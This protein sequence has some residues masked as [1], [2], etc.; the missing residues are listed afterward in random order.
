MKIIGVTGKSGSGKT[1]FAKKLA[2]SLNGV[3]VD[4]DRVSKEPLNK[5]NIIH[6][7]CE[8]FG[9]EILDEKGNIDTKKL[10]II[11]FSK[12][13]WLNELMRITQKDAEQEI[14][15]ILS[16]KDN[17]IVVL[18]WIKLPISKYWEKCDTKIL[19]KADHIKRKS[20]VLERD[21]ISEEYFEKRDLSAI[22]YEESDFNYIF[23]NNYNEKEMEETIDVISLK[24]ME[25]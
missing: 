23:K 8:K 20:K 19:V 24:I 2:K 15:D 9:N 16:K 7:L 4:V 12:E 25:D 13:E 10:G 21:N 14:D 3:Y 11:V 6:I 22:E 17:N 18:E 1:T 5:P